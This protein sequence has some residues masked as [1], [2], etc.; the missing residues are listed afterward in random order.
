MV[1]F[2]DQ[3]PAPSATSPFE[4]R[5]LVSPDDRGLAKTPALEHAADPVRNMLAASEGRRSETGQLQ[6]M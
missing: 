6:E 5:V 3:L 2:P 1:G 4:K